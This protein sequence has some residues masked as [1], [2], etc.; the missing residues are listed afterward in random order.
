VAHISSVKISSAEKDS[1][2]YILIRVASGCRGFR[3]VDDSALKDL[4]K[5]NR[6]F[7]YILLRVAKGH[8]GF[9]KVDCEARE[10]C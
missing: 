4:Q 10:W 8:E 5:G 3:K 9:R 1:P 7:L 6:A 2:L